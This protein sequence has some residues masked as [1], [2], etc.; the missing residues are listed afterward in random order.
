MKLNY[1]YEQ[2]RIFA[3]DDSGKLLA[4][5]RFPSIED[6]VV[7]F[8]STFVDPSLCGQG[9]G[10]QLVQAAIAKIKERGM[11]AVMTCSYVK[12][13]FSKHPEEGDLLA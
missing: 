1:Q 13:W 3:Q 8:S 12:A 9:V 4:E 2:D 6:G 10:E 11:K 5:I 7:N